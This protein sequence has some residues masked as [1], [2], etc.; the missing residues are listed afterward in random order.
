MIDF[1]GNTWVTDS[2]SCSVHKFDGD[3]EY[4]ASF[5]FPGNDD[6]EFEHPTGIAIWR[7]FGQLF[8]AEAE[9]ARYFWI[10]VDIRS[11]EVDVQPRGLSVEGILTEYANLRVRIL[12]EDGE[13]AASLSDG[14]VDSGPFRFEWDCLSGSR[15]TP[16]QGGEYILEIYAQPTYSSRTY[17]DKTWEYGL[18]IEAPEGASEGGGRFN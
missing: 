2:I 1:Y 9:G 17:F 6:L 3:L 12:T 13:E 4:L 10:G 14:R 8:L 11:I 15:G 16:V 18:S 7:R 5:G